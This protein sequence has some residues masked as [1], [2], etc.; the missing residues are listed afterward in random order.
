M[1]A[2]FL[3]DNP[4]TNIRHLFLINILLLVLG[5]LVDMARRPITDR[6]TDP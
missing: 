5:H 4:T 2:V 6:R 3:S 1:T